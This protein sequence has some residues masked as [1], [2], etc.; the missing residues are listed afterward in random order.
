MVKDRMLSVR[1]GAR[2]AGVEKETIRQWIAL[3]ALPAMKLPN[4]YYRIREGD[5]DGL[6]KPVEVAAGTE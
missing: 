3:G 5:L 4:G 2:R 1:E 6:L